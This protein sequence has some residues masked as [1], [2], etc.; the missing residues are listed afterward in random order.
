MKAIA[1]GALTPVQ[2]ATINAER[3]RENQPRI[4]GEVLL[5]GTHLYRS[6]VV[7]D[8]YTIEDV[9]DQIMSAMDE[10][11]VVIATPKMTAMKNLSPRRDRYGNAV[12]D[13]VIFECTARH[14]RPELFSVIPKGDAKKPKGRP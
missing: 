8:G 4:I 6:R 11:A 13:M 5:L 9:V 2:L 10:N 7:R 3:H 14:P 1:V 12:C